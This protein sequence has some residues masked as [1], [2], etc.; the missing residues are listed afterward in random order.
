MAFDD[1]AVDQRGVT[2]PGTLWDTVGRFELGDLR[3][4]DDCDF[5]SVVL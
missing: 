2:R 1:V 5:C 4:G 3:I